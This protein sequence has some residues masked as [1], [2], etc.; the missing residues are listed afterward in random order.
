MHPF[1][2]QDEVLVLLVGAHHADG[3]PVTDK[4]AVPYAPGVLVGVDVDPAREVLAIKEFTELRYFHR[5][6]LGARTAAQ[7]QH[8]PVLLFD[9][10]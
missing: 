5:Q 3:M 7:H 9:L 6:R 4:H 1:D 2:V 8:M 10:S